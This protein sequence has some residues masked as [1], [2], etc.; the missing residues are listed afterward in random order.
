MADKFC[1]MPEAIAAFN[2]AL[3]DRSLDLAALLDPKMTSEARTELFRPY[4]GD[5]AAN[6][7]RLFE[8][9]LVL[10]NRIQGIKNFAAKLGETGRYSP[11]GKAALKT[12]ADDYARAQ[13]ERIFSPKEHQA[14]LNDLADKAVGAHISKDVA[15]RIFELSDEADRLKNV[16]PSV[17]GVSDEYLQAKNAL[18]AYVADQKNKSALE[19]TIGNLA[20][21]GR[22]LKLINPSTPIKVLWSQTVNNVAEMAG[23]RLAAQ[24]LAGAVGKSA[25]AAKD[26]LWRTFRTTGVNGAAEEGGLGNI[27]L[28]KLGERMSLNGPGSFSGG[29]IGGV[30]A[31]ATG[32]GA[33]V[34]QKIAIDWEHN[35]GFARFYQSAF[36]DSANIY[37]TK[38]AKDMGLNPEDVFRDA[39]RIEPETQAGA[40][41][42]N[43][44]QQSAARVTST[45]RTWLSN[46]SMGIKQKLN[47]IAPK[48][49][50]GDF[51]VPMAKIPATVIANGIDNAGAG[52]PFG[53]R[54]IVAGKDKLKST[55]LQT[56]LEGLAQVAN[57]Y[58]RLARITGTIGLAALV[59]S[60][61]SKKD[62]RQNKYGHSFVNIGGVWIDTEYVAMFSPAIAGMMKARQ[63]GNI[64]NYATGALSGL[65]AAPGIEEIPKLIQA[66]T[67]SNLEK[68]VVRWGKD[69]LRGMFT[70]P[71]IR[72][73][74][75]DRPI[76]RLFGG[77]HGFETEREVREDEIKAAQGG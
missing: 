58:Q 36:V 1:L 46:L 68:G 15:K 26:S 17:L 50:I 34:T 10:K 24:A 44:S 13:T 47:D 61:L 30:I 37:A 52:L 9:K 14:F 38:I 41:A 66:V 49:R 40:A 11:E 4:A 20:V 33:R 18:N 63:T 53:I 35:I 45:N 77:A 28:N 8:S 72:N 70:V 74:F 71:L 39:M 16:N 32:V 73:L 7:N 3:K 65:Q 57:G 67:A 60:G 31:K 76:E 48:L 51:V 42:R 27:G 23:R 75:S 43:I 29:G 56:R 19:S 25:K 54:D 62:F 22:N 21:I 55:D 12:A 69:F 64:A 6:V 2:K 59:T 5:A